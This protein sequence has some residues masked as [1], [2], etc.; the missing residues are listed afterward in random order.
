MTINYIFYVI[1]LSFYFNSMTVPVQYK[2][3]N[4]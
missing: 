3:F 4:N 1:L 2:K